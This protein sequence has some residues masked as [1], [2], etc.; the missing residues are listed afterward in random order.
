MRSSTGIPG[1][2]A[3]IDGGFPAHRAILVCGG[4]GTG[5]TTFALQFI[6]EGLER[7]EPGI[8][9]S[10][11]EK[12]RHLIQDA[13]RLGL[14][15]EAALDSGTLAVLDAAPFFTASRGKGWGRPGVD[16]RQVAADLVQQVRR[17]GARRLAIDSITTL[18]PPDMDGGHAHDY[19]RA[20]VQSL[21]DN[22]GCT[23]LLT[24]RARPGD[25]QATCRSLRYLTSGV[26][27][28]RLSRRDDRLVRALRLLKM[29]GTAIEPADYDLTID[30]AGLS[31]QEGVERSVS[32]FT[33]RRRSVAAAAPQSSDRPAVV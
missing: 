12:P 31:V 20:V 28:L 25:P 6:G 21:E 18:V 5:K 14:P 19:L 11:D 13:A 7:G 26:I 16:A 30:A 33:P 29:R 27:E 10:L 23:L 9:V 8:F 4:P 17:L 15:L 22:L 32:R 24:C 1:L 2:D 3:L